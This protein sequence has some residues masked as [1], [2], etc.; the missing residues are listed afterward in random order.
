MDDV[1]KA[2]LA[3]ERAEEAQ[4][5]NRSRNSENEKVVNSNADAAVPVD[6]GNR[7]DEDVEDKGKGKEKGDIALT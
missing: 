2:N 5:W 1:E 7:Q 4:E 3:Q 6:Q